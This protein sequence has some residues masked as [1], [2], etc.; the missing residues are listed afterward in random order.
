VWATLYERYCTSSHGRELEGNPRVALARVAIL[1][2]SADGGCTRNDRFSFVR[3]LI[4]YGEPGELAR[5]QYTGIL[6][7]VLNVSG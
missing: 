4:P 7:D 1:S 6:G 5:Q 2:R 3:T